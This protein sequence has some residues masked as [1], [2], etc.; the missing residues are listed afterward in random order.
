MLLSSSYRPHVD[1]ISD[2][3]LDR[4]AAT[5]NPFDEHTN[6]WR[7]SGIFDYMLVNYRYYRFAEAGNL[8]TDYF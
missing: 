8:F 5:W 7:N 1:V 6:Y 3:S 4:S 2:L